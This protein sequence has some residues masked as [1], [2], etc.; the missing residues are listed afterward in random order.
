MIDLTPMKGIRVDPAARTVRA[1]GGVTWREFDRETQAFGLATTGGAISSTGIAGL[2][3]GGGFGWL[4]RSYGMS[5]RQPALGGRGAGRRQHRHRERRR[6]RRPVLGPARR[7]RQLRRRHLVRVPPPPGRPRS[8]AA[9]CSTRSSGRARCCAPLATSTS[10][11]PDEMSVFA[12][13]LTSPE[14]AKV[15]ALLVCYNGPIE[16]G[17]ALLR[18]LRESIGPIADLVGADHLR[19]AADAPGRGL[20]VRPPELLEVRVPEEP[21]GRGDRRP[22]SSSSAACRRRS[23]RWCW[24]SSAA[25][26]AASAPRRR[27]SPT[28][29]G[30]TTS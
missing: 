16:Q 20:P 3:L 29:T 10:P 13:L 9:C 11:R 30:T 24:S 4:G 23:R 5:L 14:G 22:S 28:A 27:R 12:A 19:A 8:W 18:P 21:A 26:T 2:T 6:E 1:Q 15:V 7:R 17:E 25:P